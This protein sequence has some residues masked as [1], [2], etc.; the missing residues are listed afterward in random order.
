VGFKG[1]HHGLAFFLTGLPEHLMENVPMPPV[2]AVKVPDGDDG[3]P[4]VIGYIVET[5]ENIH[6]YYT[7]A[8]SRP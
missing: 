4:E 8:L 3:P 2:H 1:D 7:F 6:I 5:V